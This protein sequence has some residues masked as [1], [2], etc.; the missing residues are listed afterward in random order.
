MKFIDMFCGMGT[1][2]MGFE[3]A[4]HECVYSIEWDKHKRRIYDVIFGKEPEGRDIRDTRTDE[5]PQSDCWVAG[6]P[7]QDISVA[8]KQVGFEGNRSSL[9][10][11][12][13]RLLH[14]TK[15]ENRPKYL[16]FEN[17]KNF[18]SVN[19]GRDF[20]T[21]LIEMDEVGYDSEWDLLNSK[22]FGVP[23]NRERVFIVGHLRG[24]STRKVFPIAGQS[25][26]YSTIG[27]SAKTAVA[28]TLTAG[29][30]S[31][32]NHSG[33]TILQIGNLYQR[34]GRENPNDGRVYDVNGIAPCLNK[35][36]GGN[37]QPFIKVQA[38][39]TP[40]RLEKR[41]NGRRMKEDGEPMFTLTG[42]D[43]HGVMITEATKKG[44]S[45]AYEG[46]SINLAVPGSKTRR[47][48]V[49]VGVANTLDTSC[50]QG[51]LT[52][53]R[54]RRLTPRECLR[55]QGVPEYIIDKLINAGISDTQLYRAAG[56]AWSVPVGYE[57]ARRLI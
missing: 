34:E 41:Q 13:M 15:E 9:Y 37:R 21:A 56:D 8:G 46:D 49:G 22:N 54:I 29:G 51:T 33:M 20:L 30:H 57:I 24:R 48:R 26:E 3:Q 11:Q 40:D 19:G 44:Y 35:M 52:Q 2:R 1:A 4:G 28:R 55:L 27:K 45:E 12:V 10:F 32:G 7:C 39:L 53:G 16:L 17:V 47:G 18:F 5:L 25:N 14:E 36:E 31:G 50:N 6:F 42:Q 23:Q 43:R 38:V